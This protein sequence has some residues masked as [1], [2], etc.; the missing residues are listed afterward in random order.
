[1]SEPSTLD[2]LRAFYERMFAW[3]RLAS[4]LDSLVDNNHVGPDEAR[5]EMLRSLHEIGR[6]FLAD[7]DFED[8]VPNYSQPSGY[9]WEDVARVR[10]ERC[11][12][13]TCL[14]VEHGKR[15]H[16]A[17]WW[18]PVVDERRFAGRFINLNGHLIGKLL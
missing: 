10:E 1:M 9:D 12:E 4:R 2:R 7:F 15:Y 16:P 8:F 11:G 18:F 13:R 5:A 6:E 14:V 17:E 3:E